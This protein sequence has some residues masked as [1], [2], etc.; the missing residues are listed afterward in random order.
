MTMS[1]P[2]RPR[3]RA[4]QTTASVRGV[5]RPRSGG[6]DR[7]AA[8]IEAAQ[9]LFAE[10]GF[11]RTTTRAVAARA[12]V[13]VAMIYHHFASKDDLL[14][15]ALAVPETARS[16]LQPLP[17]DTADPGRAV[18]ATLITM[19]DTDPAIRLQGLAMIRTALSHPYAAQLLRHLQETAVL[20]LIQNLVAPDQ[21]AFRA[22]L[23]G[24]Y[25]S[26]LVLNR[27]LLQVEAISA[28]EPESLIAATAPVINRCLTGD[29]T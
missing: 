21:Q 14:V 10:H 27:H 18:A 2:M 11:E 19:W 20:T 8:I 17:A 7:R 4:D 29:L 24:A 9:E 3:R 22:G 13:D 26:G 5:G 28:A 23:I 1:V 15:H 6:R 12:G 16:L 25:L